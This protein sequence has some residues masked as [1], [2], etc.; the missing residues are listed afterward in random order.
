[1]FVRCA[2]SCLFLQ[3]AIVSA[4]TT[5]PPM[6]SKPSFELA[7]HLSF[8]ITHLL[9][10]ALLIH[11]WRRGRIRAPYLVLLAVLA[12]QQMS[13]DMSLKVPV[14]RSLVDVIVRSGQ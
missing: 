12:L 11:D 7:F 5:P 2:L 4:A 14:W 10:I 8:V 1:M 9:V 6:M 13:F 3:A